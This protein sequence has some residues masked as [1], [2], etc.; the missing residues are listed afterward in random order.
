MDRNTWRR[1]A[2]SALWPVG[3][4]AAAGLVVLAMTDKRVAGVRL[5]IV[6]AA[7]TGL[8]YT[9]SGLI[10]ARGR[11]DNRL[12]ALMV[13]LGLFWLA[14]WLAE[15]S[16]SSALFTA[17]IFANDAWVVPFAYF[18]VSFPSGSRTSRAD[19]LPVAA[20]AV[21]VVPLEVA[22]L[23]FLDPGPP[24]N[25][26]QVWN[27]PGVADA[28]DWVQRVILT[29]AALALTA[30]LANRWRTASAP[31]RRRLTPILAG[32][33]AVLVADGNLL[34]DKI[35]GHSAP[36]ALQIA[37]VCALAAVPV[38]VLVDL[39]RARLARSA[40]GDLVVALR[41]DPAPGAVR[42][43]MARALG[44]PSL[45][46]AFWLPDRGG[47]ADA[48]G[49]PV[50]LGDDPERVTTM[51]DF[52]GE[53]VAV[54]VHDPSLRG[55]PELLDAVGAAAG[56]ALENARL[57]AEVLAGVEELRGTRGRIIEAAQG[58]R[59]RLARGLH[60]GARQRLFALSLRLGMLEARFGT[61]PEARGAVA[62]ARSE[63]G[64]SL[65]ELRELA[66][67]IHPAVVTGHG[68]A[69]ALEGL[70]ARAPVPVQV[71]VDLDARLPEPIEVAA[72]FL[73]SEGLT[74]VA[75]YARASTA[76]IDVSRAN[77]DLVVEVSDDGVGGANADGGTGLRG[78]ADRVE[79]L[80][81]CLRLQ[82]PAGGGTRMRAQI[83]CA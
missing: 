58:E 42:D 53:R 48:G 69:A 32:A 70:A 21:T 71:T 28:I 14:G 75:K 13:A 65:S 34:V 81:G 40:V 1:V 56:F 19:R 66:R 22:F 29:G 8:A 49:Q 23:L 44:D 41:R 35:S 46:V 5:D 43:A 7:I 78:L 37:V 68:L 10:A 15:F 2:Y 47:Y 74:N 39:L 33:A 67:G 20:F 45:Q 30:L 62:Q 76:S 25:A 73:V 80:G 55:E 64:E 26:L 77:G 3:L 79:A 38:A 11:P 61:D 17:A 27:D 82:S 72:Y 63:L 9:A 51:V 60:D 36:H 6:L 54:L 16:H 52:S 4:A 57:H 12:G 59:R 50:E 18:L 24:G 83:P 31:L